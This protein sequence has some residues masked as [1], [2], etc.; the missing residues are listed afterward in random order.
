ME[1]NLVLFR[2][3]LCVN[4]GEGTPPALHGGK[5]KHCSFIFAL[6]VVTVVTYHST[7]VRLHSQRKCANNLRNY[8]V[9]IIYRRVNMFDFHIFQVTYY[10]SMPTW[11][12]LGQESPTFLWER[13]TPLTVCWFAGYLW[14]CNSKWYT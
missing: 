12:V 5:V 3:C 1:R 13:T 11:H 6:R 14:K 8:E 4:C 10:H 7:H 9:R 2:I